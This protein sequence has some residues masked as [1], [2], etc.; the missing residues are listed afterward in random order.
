M[1]IT[2]SQYESIISKYRDRLSKET[3]ERN[4]RISHIY[5]ALPALRELDNAL[6]NTRTALRQQIISGDANALKTVTTAI[7]ETTSKKNSLL[8]AAG[9]DPRDLDI[10]YTCTDCKDTGYLDNGQKCHCLK[11][12]II[13]LLYS[14]S[15][16]G[17]D[18]LREE[19]FDN[20]SLSYYSS[21][22]DP[23][24]GLT[25]LELAQNALR[26]SL[27]FVENFS[28]EFDNILFYGLPGVGKTFLSNC[29]AGQLIKQGHSVI[30]LSAYDFFEA[31]R[32]KTFGKESDSE[33]HLNEIEQC[34]LLIIDDLGTEFTNSFTVTAL[35]QCINTRLLLKKSTIIST[36]LDPA[37]LR[38]TY[39]ERIISR[40]NS[41]YKYF[42]LSGEDIRQKR[43]NK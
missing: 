27:N 22:I 13:K 36:N 33:A 17:E 6:S 16:L 20:F 28:K 43:R 21:D 5:D 29:I 38:D 1:P 34:D 10:H 26:G 12:E 30:Y 11:Q 31:Y 25:Y 8:R 32:N 7:D 19:C 15:H 2:N 41:T 35:F 3:E 24:T 42:K 14:D 4:Q 37:T 40:I 39:Q 18:L 23:S 9:F